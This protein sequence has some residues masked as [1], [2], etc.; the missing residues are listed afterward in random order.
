VLNV[1]ERTAEGHLE[2]IRDRLGFHSRTEIAHWAVE[3]RPAD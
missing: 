1:A 3:R 2:R